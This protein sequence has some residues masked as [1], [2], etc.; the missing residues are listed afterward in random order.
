MLIKQYWILLLCSGLSIQWFNNGIDEFQCLNMDITSLW[1]VE[2]IQHLHT[3]IN[4]FKVY[5]HVTK[6]EISIW[7]VM[8]VCVSTNWSHELIHG[9]STDL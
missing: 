5:K 2:A 8:V 9:L 1:R 3:W 7:V 6:T 4:Y